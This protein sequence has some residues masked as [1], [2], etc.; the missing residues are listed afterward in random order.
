[1]NDNSEMRIFYARRGELSFWADREDDDAQ[2]APAGWYWIPGWC[3]LD[4]GAFGP[5]PSEAAAMTAA[6]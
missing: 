6:N 1:M 3:Y 4:S 2:P 5:Y